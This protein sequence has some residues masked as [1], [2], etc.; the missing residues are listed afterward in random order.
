MRFMMIVR[1]TEKQGPP[2]K[3]LMDAIGK[4]ADEESKSGRML[5]R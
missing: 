5:C 4:L 1:H 2:P 3:S